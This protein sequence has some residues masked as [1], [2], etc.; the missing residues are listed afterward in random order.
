MH[1]MQSIVIDVRGVFPSVTL[2]HG[3]TRLHCAKTAEQIKILFGMNTLGAP[4]NIVSDGGPDP[5]QQGE[6]ELYVIHS[7]QPLPDYFELLLQ[8]AVLCQGA[9]RLSIHLL[10]LLGSK[11]QRSSRI[12]PGFVVLLLVVFVSI[13]VS[14]RLPEMTYSVSGWTLS[15]T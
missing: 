3:S 14:L 12:M 8:P 7:M 4:K 2:S 9:V 5:P 6:G 13:V 11:G 1:E 15:R 10:S